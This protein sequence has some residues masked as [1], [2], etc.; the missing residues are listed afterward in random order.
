MKKGMKELHIAVLAAAISIFL[1][2]CQSVEEQKTAVELDG[3]AVSTEA[4]ML[5]EDTEEVLTESVDEEEP[6]PAQ[7]EEEGFFTQHNSQDIFI[8]Y[9][10]C[11][12][13]Y[14]NGDLQIYTKYFE[15]GNEFFSDACTVIRLQTAD[16]NME[17]FAANEYCIDYENGVVYYVGRDKSD[18]F[19]SIYV[20]YSYD[21]GYWEVGGTKL[22]NVY[23]VEDWLAETFGLTLN[24]IEESFSDRR[25]YVTALEYEQGIPILKGEASGVH[26]DTGEYC[27]VDWEINT[28]TGERKV[29]PHE[30][31]IYDKEKDKEIFEAC[32][33]AFTEKDGGNWLELSDLNDWKSLVDWDSME[34]GGQAVIVT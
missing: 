19:V 28:E 1:A 34:A 27:H 18:D 21:V 16:S 29:S 32:D 5:L 13:E 33:K 3:A 24:D 17:I 12:C 11:T 31:T 10:D 8:P 9:A 6:Q 4:T 30:K 15:D 14:D 7:P 25:V 26:K 23:V 22:L 20:Y 2:G